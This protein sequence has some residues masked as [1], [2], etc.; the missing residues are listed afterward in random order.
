MWPAT[1]S[2]LGVVLE[3]GKKKIKKK[4]NQVL[5]LCQ[6]ALRL[7]GRWRVLGSLRILKAADAAQLMASG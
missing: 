3:K 4:R 5:L 2:L 7:A 1:R 6:P